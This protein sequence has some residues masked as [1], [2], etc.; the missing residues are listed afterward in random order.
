M[1]K[2]IVMIGGGIAGVAAARELT[3]PHFTGSGK[4]LVLNKGGRAY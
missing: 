1:K 3:R 4:K 2:T